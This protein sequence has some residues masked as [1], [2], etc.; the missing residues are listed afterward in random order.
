MARIELTPQEQNMLLTHCHT[1]DS[2]TFDRITNAQ[3]G[4]LH[5]LIDECYELQNSIYIAIEQSNDGEVKDVLGQVFTKLTPNPQSRSILEELSQYDFDSIEEANFKAQNIRSSHNTAP[6]PEMGGLSPDQVN[7]LIYLPWDDNNFPLKFNK[8]LTQA[9]VKDSTF[10]TNTTIFLKTLIEMEKEPTA[11]ATGNLNRKIVKNLFD[12]LI[13]D[14][15]DKKFTLE[16]N[17]VINEIDVFPLHIVKIV[18]EAVGLIHKR[19]NK[20]LV[21]KKHQHLI[22]EENVGELYYLLFSSYFTKF[23]IGYLDRLAELD[24][25]QHTVEY[26]FYRLKEIA[27]SYIGIKDLVDKILL[28]A[29]VQEV[30]AGLTEPTRIEWVLIARIIRPLEGFGLLECQYKKG[31]WRDTI[32]KVRKTKLFDRFVGIEW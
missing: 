23:N 27:D 14:E 17:K 20:F 15:D 8:E 13:L 30:I 7:R 3:N 6:D 5:L 4:V 32:V 16:Y 2:G 24:C 25:I 9:D 10:F 21:T 18:C 19:K 12:K 29:V 26:S 1:I 28:P 22:S 11:T 31:E